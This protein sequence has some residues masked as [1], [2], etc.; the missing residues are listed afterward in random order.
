VVLGS[1]SQILDDVRHALASY[2]GQSELLVDVPDMAVLYKQVDAVIVSGGVSLLEC[3]AAGRPSCV[4]QTADNQ[5]GNVR[6]A[7]S[8]GGTIDGGNIASWDES[9]FIEAIRLLCSSAPTR[10][11]LVTKARRAV[12]GKG[13]ERVVQAMTQFHQSLS[14]Q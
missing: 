14:L 5:A 6:Q 8:S 1:T 12:D 10:R 11:G 4:V 2:T 3:L 7:L 13:A 9:K